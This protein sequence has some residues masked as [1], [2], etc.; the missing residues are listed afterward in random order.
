MSSVE[1]VAIP[2]ERIAPIALETASN[3]KS[4]A[5]VLGFLFVLMTIAMFSVIG[6]DTKDDKPADSAERAGYMVGKALSVFLFAGVPGL[7]AVRIA[8]SASRA[9]RAAEV[10]KGDPATTWYLSGRLVIAD[11]SGTLRPELSFKISRKSRT[12]LLALP[13]ADVIH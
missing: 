3:S 4:V 12:M 6:D 11:R 13:R 5:A 1:S 2:G 10:A 7:L 8:R 9:T